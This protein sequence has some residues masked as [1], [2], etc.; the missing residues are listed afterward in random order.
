[1]KMIF[2]VFAQEQNGKYFAV[3]DTIR[4][5]QN[6]TAYIYSGIIPKYATCA[7]AENRR[8]KSPPHGMNHTKQ[9]EQI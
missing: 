6:L 3:A 4:T 2:V 9:T 1:M 8:R 5:G 7:K